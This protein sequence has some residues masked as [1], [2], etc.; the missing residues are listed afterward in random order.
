MHLEH[1]LRLLEP[2]TYLPTRSSL[3]ALLLRPLL[4]PAVCSA[5]LLRFLLSRAHCLAARLS[6]LLLLLTCKYGIWPV[7]T[8]THC[9]T[10]CIFSTA[11]STCCCG[12]RARRWTR[13]CGACVCGS[14]RCACTRA[15]VQNSLEL[16]T[17]TRVRL[18]V[19]KLRTLLLGAEQELQRAEAAYIA[20]AS[21]T[22]ELA[23]ADSDLAQHCGCTNLYNALNQGAR[24]PRSLDPRAIFVFYF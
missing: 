6:L 9:R 4:C 12:N 1:L 5:P 19:N 22:T 2:E 13:P 14:R 17:L 16:N 3:G 8:C 18:E 21:S 15:K 11:A 7:R 23:Q 10:L 20:Q 24:T